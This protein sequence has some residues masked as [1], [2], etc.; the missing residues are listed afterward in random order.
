MACTYRCMYCRGKFTVACIA[1][2]S[3]LLHVL[4]RQVHCCVYCRGKFTVACCKFTVACCKFTVACIAEASSL[5][6]VLQRQVHCCMLQVHCCLYCRGKFIVACIAEASSL[7]RVLQRQV[8]CC[9]YC[10][11]KFTVACCKFTV[12]CIAEASSLLRVLQRQVHCC[13]YRLQRLEIFSVGFHF[14]TE[15]ANREVKDVVAFHAG[16]FVRVSQVL[17][18]DLHEP[19]LSQVRKTFPHNVVKPHSKDK[20]FIGERCAVYIAITCEDKTTLRSRRLRW[21]ILTVVWIILYVM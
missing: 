18:L 5:L 19:P 13:M 20:I 14:R 4:Q 12:A 7:F 17:Q 11:G 16:D 8:H 6:R 3:S 15:K 1:E 10:R 2:A 9:L 21:I